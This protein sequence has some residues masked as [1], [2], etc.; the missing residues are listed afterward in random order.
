VIANLHHASPRLPGLLYPLAQMGWE[1]TIVTAPLGEN[2]EAMLGFP[3]GFEQRV[4]IVIADYKGDIFWRLRSLLRSIGFAS[5]SSYT[6]QLKSRVGK[7]GGSYVDKLMRTYQ[8]LFAIPDTEWTW[9]SAA[10][11]VAEQL[12]QSKN[13]DAI[14]SSSPFPTVHFIAAKIKRKFFM[15]WIADF[16]DPWSQSHNYPLPKFRLLLDRWLE[17]RLIASADVISTVSEGF[18]KKLKQLHGNKVIVIPNGYQEVDRH[19]QQSLPEVLTFSYTGTIYSGK[20]DPYKILRALQELL[21][22][23]TIAANRVV[24]N[25]YGRHDSELAQA[26]DALELQTTVFQCGS[27]ARSEIRDIQSNTHV[28]V[29]FQWEDLSESGIFPLK[30]YEYLDAGRFILATGGAS[31]TEISEILTMTA[32]GTVA[33]NVNEIKAIISQLYQEFYETGHINYLGNREQ[34]SSYSYSAS[35]E[36]LLKCL[37]GFQK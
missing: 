15:P 28:L 7:A 27:R 29:L 10:Y 35:A 33:P 30:F 18:S 13:Y 25:I 4:K 16:R 2:A 17:K 23:G 12:A 19:L 32:S 5:T 31:L 22:D 9:H 24:F 20:Q 3:P 6:E 14:L 8:A 37:N 34:I 26:I 11:R 21:A 1:I 36:K